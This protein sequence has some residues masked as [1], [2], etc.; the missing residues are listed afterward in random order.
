[1]PMRCLPFSLSL[2]LAGSLLGLSLAACSGGNGG[3]SD[4]GG[5]P[6]S[7]PPQGSSCAFED[8]LTCNYGASEGVCGGGTIATCTNGTW[9]YA[10]TPS[11]AGAI[12]ACPATIP[13]QGSPCSLSG[14]GAEPSCSYGCDQGGPAYATC[15][16][17]TWNVSLR[18]ASPAMSTPETPET[19]PRAAS[20]A[21]RM[22]IVPGAIIAMR[23]AAH[24]PLASARVRLARPTRSARMR[25]SARAG[26]ALASAS[27]R[28]T[29]KDSAGMFARRLA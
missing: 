18:R 17:S 10:E 7:A 9:Q 12:Q 3:G 5:C 19:Q 14:C 2:V 20:A 28:S 23:R 21:T 11:G 13:A 29:R 8:G 24:T 26:A 22:P 25:A 15:N 4:A 6:P 16:G 1:M 27:P